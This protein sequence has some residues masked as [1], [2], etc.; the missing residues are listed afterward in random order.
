MDG[1]GLLQ[2]SFSICLNQQSPSSLTPPPP[3]PKKKFKKICMVSR[4]QF[5]RFLVDNHINFNI[6]K[7][8]HDIMK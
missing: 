2:V 4:L 3:P 1:H 8:I 5:N 7:V 6:F